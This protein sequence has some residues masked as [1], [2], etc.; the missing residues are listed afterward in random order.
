MNKTRTLL[1]GTVSLLVSIG[2]AQ[3]GTE[4]FTAEY[5]SSGTS[6]T[7][8]HGVTQFVSLPYFNSSLG[9]LTS[10]SIELSE[11]TTTNATVTNTGASS[12]NGNI[13]SSIV[14]NIEAP[15]S[16]P[17]GCNTLTV[18]NAH[19]LVGAA[20][21]FFQQTGTYSAGFATSIGP[22]SAATSATNSSVSNPS[23]YVGTGSFDLPLYADVHT[24]QGFSG[25]NLTV[26]QTTTATAIV[27]ITYTYTSSQNVPEPASMALLGTGLLGLAGLTRRS[28]TGA[29]SRRW[30]WR[31]R[32]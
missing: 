2:A 14:M 9:T 21:V 20:D 4:S 10:V 8:W 24:N 13:T 7:P 29:E 12:I 27:E 30:W 23:S 16:C 26:S 25:G 22:I 15:G 32:S 31:R 19:K 3:A 5:P 28:R 11:A 17:S 1:L 6:T 18:A